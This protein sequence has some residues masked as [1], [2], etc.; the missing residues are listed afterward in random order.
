MRRQQLES[1]PLPKASE[2]QPPPPLQL[3]SANFPP[4]LDKSF[5]TVAFWD[6]DRELAH[7]TLSAVL[8]LVGW[9]RTKVW[10]DVMVEVICTGFSVLQKNLSV[11]MH[12]P[13]DFIIIFKHRHDHDAIVDCRNFNLGNLD[14]WRHAC[15]LGPC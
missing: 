3:D 6:M 11:T 5:V 1:A 4:A 9:D 15:G 7:L 14:V 8:V 10:V 2:P 12:C 13:E